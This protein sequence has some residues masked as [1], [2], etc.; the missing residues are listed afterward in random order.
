M[1]CNEAATLI[2]AYADGEIDGLRSHL[3]KRHLLGCAGCAIQCQRC[4][5]C[6]RNFAPGTRVA[7][8]PRLKLLLNTSQTCSTST[9][10]ESL[11]CVACWKWTLPAN[12]QQRIPVRPAATVISNEITSDAPVYSGWRPCE[13]CRHVLGRCRDL[14]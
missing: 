7:Y 14:A 8:V 5:R 1:N 4:W 10:R 9:R 13:H 6:V 2:A 12:M 11:S 3:L